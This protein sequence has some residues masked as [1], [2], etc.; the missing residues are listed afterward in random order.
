MSLKK[1]IVFC[2]LISFFILSFAPS[3]LA[4]ENKTSEEI[5]VSL[6]IDTSGSMAETDPANLR[7]M[8]A[9]IFVD[10]LSPEDYLG[11]VSFSTDVT[12]LAAMQQI[13]DSNNKQAIKRTLA[14]IINANGNTN[15]QL[16]LQTAEKQLDSFT[17]KDI[18][19]VI[20][21][22]TDGVPEP[23]YAKREDQVF[24]S[25]Y[26]NFL[27]QTTAQIGLK[28]Y[29]VY[30]LG[31]G[32]ADPSTLQRIATDTRGEAK[33]LGNP[34]EIAVNF[35][36]V[37]RTLKNRQTFLNETIDVAGENSLPFQIDSYTS[38]VTMV[39]TDDTQGIEV[40][41][42]PTAGQNAADKVV[43]QKNGNYTIVTMNQDDKELAGDWQLLVK[44]TGKVQL[45]GDK[46]LF[47]KS[48]VVEP[49]ANM[50][51]PVNEPIAISVAVT[52]ELDPQ[53][54]VE[55]QV[56]KDGTIDTDTIKLALQ[57]GYYVG[58]Y[59]NV[60]QTGE[61]I[62]DTRIK[63]G[64]TIVTN[65][66]TTIKVQELPVLI[67][68]VNLQDAIFKVSESQKINGYLE[69]SG[70]LVDSSQG[71][72]INSFNLVADYSDGRQ[73]I[74]S[75]MDN[76]DEASGDELGGDG[77]Y[78]M[79]LPFGSEGEVTASLNVQGTYDGLNFTVE[80]ELG[81]YKVVSA[82][83]VTGTLLEKKL[84]GKPG[85]RVSI[86]IKLEN[87]SGRSETVHLSM[88]SDLGVTE[89]KII[90]L[91][92][93]ETANEAVSI[94]IFKETPLSKQDLEIMLTA[95]DPLTSVKSNIKSTISVISGSAMLIRNVQTFIVK[96]WYVVILV[97]L[98]PLLIL[99]VGKILYLQKVKRAM[100]IPRYMQYK[101]L[102]SDYDSDKQQEIVLPNTVGKI[103]ISFGKE[104]PTAN[105]VLPESKYS[106][107]LTV[108]VFERQTQRKWLEGYRTLS[109]SYLPVRIEINT[110]PPGIFKSDGE[111]FT[112]K[113]IFD[114]DTFE[115][116]GYQF[117]YRAAKVLVPEDKA[118]NL[119]EGKL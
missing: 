86:P 51:H 41:A 89:E 44:G 116:G 103:V 109:K 58:S 10:L 69:L 107:L 81:Q 37:L 7:K 102:D 113:E 73:E 5:A 104:D 35:F 20:I 36:E 93:Y 61:Y 95:E 16:A 49:K 48:W 8:A 67:S 87:H 92:P 97:I 63:D 70:N 90:T 85:G 9:D 99:A 76:Q 25:D 13:G 17:E 66:L 18:R 108:N 55:V 15:Y 14:P 24:M 12:E 45:F 75:L 21:F 79:L 22:L 101:T 54:S 105:L 106:Y 88:E 38:Q 94:A 52:G 72:S 28:N 114:Q 3:V 60:D 31:F 62:L 82:G 71:V 83:E 39:V 115:S 74:H 110:T 77:I 64:E 2:F 119:L 65:N 19:K 59:E 117:T 29:P 53:M 98:L 112:N 91:D 26:M 111:V 23:D 68:E 30:A 42:N 57:D 43:V 84:T 33:F 1:I 50:Q 96:S 11:I 40:S 46:D 47:L 4:E 78:T 80:K 32:T 118:K 100:R 34:S 56:S 6:V 27:W